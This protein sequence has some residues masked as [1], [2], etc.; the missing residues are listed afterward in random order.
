[1]K[2]LLTQWEPQ[3][4]CYSPTDLGEEEKLPRITFKYFLISKKYLLRAKN[5]SEHRLHHVLDSWKEMR[6][7]GHFDF[8]D[9]CLNLHLRVSY[10]F[11]LPYFL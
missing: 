1:M 11:P 9:P 10:G 6:L 7:A 5:V 4:N 2:I 3:S 8:C